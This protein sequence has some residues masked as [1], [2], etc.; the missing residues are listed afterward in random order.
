MP[1]LTSVKWKGFFIH[2]LDRIFHSN[3]L[4]IRVRH[5]KLQQIKMVNRIRID[6]VPGYVSR[7]PSERI[8]KTYLTG[9]S[10]LILIFVSRSRGVEASTQ[11]PPSLNLMAVDLPPIGN[12]PYLANGLEE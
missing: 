10:S 9:P 4:G 2:S 11:T 3:D 1:T 6:D 7:R 5:F 12:T 8:Q